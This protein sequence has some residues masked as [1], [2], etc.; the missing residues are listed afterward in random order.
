M[1]HSAEQQLLPEHDNTMIAC[2]GAVGPQTEE[3]SEAEQSVVVAVVAHRHVVAI[4]QPLD[5]RS[6]GR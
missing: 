2:G 4:G 3:S 5:K 1:C 6:M